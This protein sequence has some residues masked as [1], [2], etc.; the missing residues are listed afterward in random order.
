MKAIMSPLARRMLD[1]GKGKELMK[2]T[3]EHEVVIEFEGKKYRAIAIPP[4]EPKEL[5]EW[6]RVLIGTIVAFSVFGVVTLSFY[7]FLNA[8]LQYLEIYVFK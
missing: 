4:K 6:K 7:S 1:A 5:P 8:Y 3:S 2:V